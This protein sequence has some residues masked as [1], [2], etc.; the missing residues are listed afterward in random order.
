MLNERGE[1]LEA[2]VQLVGSKISSTLAGRLEK[3][4]IRS[5]DAMAGNRLVGGGLGHYGLEDEDEDDMDDVDQDVTIVLL[6]VE[7]IQEVLDTLAL[8]AAHLALVNWD[9]WKPHAVRRNEQDVIMRDR[10]LCEACRRKFATQHLSQ[11]SIYAVAW[12]RWC[13][14]CVHHAD[15]DSSD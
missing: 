14:D 15:D 12:L 5:L 13:D 10:A 11:P 8:W 9:Q 3:D 1:F 6:K 2:I 7:V 4:C